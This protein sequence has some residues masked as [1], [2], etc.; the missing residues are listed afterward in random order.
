VSGGRRTAI[1][2]SDEVLVPFRRHQRRLLD[3]DRL[4]FYSD[5]ISRRRTSDGLFGTQGIAKAAKAA[6]ARSATA[7]AR[8]IQEA[9]VNASED[10]LPDDAAVIELGR[11][12]RDRGRR[13]APSRLTRRKEPQATRRIGLAPARL[14]LPRRFFQ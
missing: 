2:H 1:H 11:Q 3:D 5:G 9:V 4:V 6:E 8:A 7:T 10:P 13:S 14:V 12:R